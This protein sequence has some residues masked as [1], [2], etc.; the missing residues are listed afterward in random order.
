MII[1][2]KGIKHYGKDSTLKISTLYAKAKR[3]V[4]EYKM[5]ENSDSIAVA[6]SGGKDS[7]T[8]LYA[9]HGLSYFKDADFK[10]HAVMVDMGFDSFDPS[11]T[12]HICQKLSI[13]FTKIKTNLG[14]II[15]EERREKNPCSVCATMRKGIINKTLQELGCNKI[16]Y[17]H[18]RD[19]FINT[20][21]LSLLREGRFHTME[22]KFSMS[23]SGL[24]LIRPLLYVSESEIIEFTRKNDLKISKNPCPA[25]GITDRS[26]V[27]NLV[28]KLKKSFPDCEER[29]FRAI[30]EA[31]FFK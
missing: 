10:L 2:S 12:E 14:K 25:D 18:H 9:L 17:G 3:A 28:S 29:F 24:T 6:V 5:I 15:F 23:R 31:N 30:K 4:E 8:L 13:P 1:H 21:L 11:P 26:T 7:L 27:S 16:A 22:P 20:M 19:D